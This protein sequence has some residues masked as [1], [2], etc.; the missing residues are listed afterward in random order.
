VVL[1]AVSTLCL[2][3]LTTSLVVVLFTVGL[4]GCFF[5]QMYGLPTLPFFLFPILYEKLE[6]CLQTPVG[7]YSPRGLWKPI[8]CCIF[9]NDIIC[10]EEEKDV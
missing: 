2:S 1:V 5:W 4:L 7:R 9:V 10:I 3:G 6:C 8:H